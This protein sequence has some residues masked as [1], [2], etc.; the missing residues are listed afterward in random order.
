MYGLFAVLQ[1][2]PKYC[3][4]VFLA[5]AYFDFSACAPRLPFVQIV[6]INIFE[7]VFFFL[8][9]LKTSVI[10]NNNLH[11]QFCGLVYCISPGIAEKLALPFGDNLNSN[12]C[13]V[14]L[15][16]AD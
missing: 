15:L 12:F 7:A 16:V 2:A 10:S 11:V 6:L 9:F 1:Y 5:V 3:A 8:P 4:L 13:P 14:H